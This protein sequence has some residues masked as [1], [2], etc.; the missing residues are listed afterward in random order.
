MPKEQIL[1]V[2][3]VDS[4][5][6]FITINLE[7]EGYEVYQA[8]RGQ[9]AIKMIE[10]FFF[11]LVI[12]D[13]MLPDIDGLKILKFI[14]KV[15]PETMV[16]MVTGYA[17][18]DSSILAMKEGAFSYIIKP[19]ELSELLITMKKAL[20]KQRLSIE[21]KQLLEELKKAN[22]ELEEANLYLEQKVKER[23]RE[24]ELLNEDLNKANIELKRLDKLKDEL[25]SLVS[26]D[27]KSP[28]TAIIGYAST[29]QNKPIHEIGEEKVKEYIERI[30]NQSYRML[31]LINDILDEQKV[32]E[33]KMT[34]NAEISDLGIIGRECYEEI[35]ILAAEK[36]MEIDSELPDA[37][38]D[39]SKIRQVIINLL[40][41]AIKFTPEGGKVHLKVY[42][43][44]RKLWISIADTGPGI[45]KSKQ[46]ELFKEFK[47][48]KTPDGKEYEGT[49]LGLSIC[50]KIIT[51]HGGKI[52]VQSEVNK[53]SKFSFSLPV[54]T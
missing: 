13:I 43:G 23:T 2:D 54:V 30:L 52:W 24:L 32:K 8:S 9:E 46:E 40:S 11:N 18:L 5:R 44:K 39:R 51:L 22:K 15:S 47:K 17:S 6:S 36:T 35:K 31:N 16:I 26:H 42:Q 28:L 38:L 49:G 21:N 37:F 29:I 25:I 45:E 53:G 1:V 3:D 4:I 7:C 34:L 41:N 27:L 20:G 10:A 14:R 50:K 33:G 48:L 12:L 19:F